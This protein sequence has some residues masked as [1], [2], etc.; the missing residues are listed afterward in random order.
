MG[1]CN[2]KENARFFG[3]REKSENEDLKETMIEL[4]RQ[5]GVNIVRDEISTCHRLGTAG[6]HKTRAVIVRFVRRDVKIELMKCSKYLRSSN[7]FYSVFVNED[8]STPRTRLFTAL[9]T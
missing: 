6:R 7:D 2:R 9:R 4:G 5:V 3:L 1:K 8:L